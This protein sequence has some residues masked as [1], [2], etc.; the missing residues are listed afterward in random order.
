MPKAAFE[1]F[2]E[3]MF[4][5]PDRNF[6]PQSHPF[7]LPAVQQMRKLDLRQPVTILAGEN[8]SG[9]STLIEALAVAARFNSEGG[10]KNFWFETYS[11]DKSLGDLITLK[12]SGRRERDG[13]FLRAES[14]WA[15]NHYMGQLEPPLYGFYGGD[16]HK[17]SHGE[18]FMA[19]VMNRFGRDS[20]Y[21]FDEPESALSPARQ[22]QLLLR[23]KQ[24]VDL[25][26]QFIVATHS[27]IIMAYPGARIYWLSDAGI[28]ET[29]WQ[30]TE[31][32]SVMKRVLSDRDAYLASMGL[33]IKSAA[34]NEPDLFNF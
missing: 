21:L 34:A 14:Y 11:E 25:R 6:D 9:K 20:L 7:C 10:T 32:Y 18:S 28:E 13:F 22:L 15:A 3:Q 8:G 12:R 33:S 23:M 26:C 1:S 17:M 19:L 5:H 2:V 16:P 4:I 30:R 27:P 31:H 24:L 29:E